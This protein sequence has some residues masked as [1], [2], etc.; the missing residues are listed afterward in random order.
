[1]ISSVNQHQATDLRLVNN[2]W[3]ITGPEHMDLRYGMHI[4]GFTELKYELTVSFEKS[5]TWN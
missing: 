3:I 4:V 2:D 5:V 1:M